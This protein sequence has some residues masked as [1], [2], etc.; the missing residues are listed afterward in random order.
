M[1]SHW[2]VKMRKSSSLFLNLPARKVDIYRR[3]LFLEGAYYDT[4]YIC[5]FCNKIFIE[6]R[7]G[8]L[9]QELWRNLMK[10]IGVCCPRVIYASVGDFFYSGW[11]YWKW[12]LSIKARCVTA[13]IIIGK[14]FCPGW[15]KMTLY[16]WSLG[17]RGLGG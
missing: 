4:F 16:T 7:F 9:W 1:H 11:I 3:F 6:N 10:Y 2:A 5:F 15:F 17:R 13:Y 8:F 14:F 12:T